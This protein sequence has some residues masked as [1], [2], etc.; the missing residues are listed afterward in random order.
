MP[1]LTSLLNEDCIAV[2]VDAVTWEDAVRAAGG[3]LEQ[4]GI[5][6]PAYTAAMVDN[7]E[8]NGP[9]IVV[10]PGFAF[11]HARPSEA[12]RFRHRRALRLPLPRRS[13]QRRFAPASTATTRYPLLRSADA[14]PLIVKRIPSL[15]DS[16]SS[17]PR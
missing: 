9:Y 10:A 2:D 3:L 14:S 5:A 17:P 16:S 11:A 1:G 12:R 8:T 6:G 15:T 4:T 13:S 7:V